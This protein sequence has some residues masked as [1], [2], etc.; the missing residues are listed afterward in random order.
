MTKTQTIVIAIFVRRMSRFAICDSRLAAF[1][2]PPPMVRRRMLPRA[3]LKVFC[4]LFISL[5]CS[6]Q[7]ISQ[8]LI[9]KG[10]LFSKNS[11]FTICT[12]LRFLVFF[13]FSSHFNR[14]LSSTVSLFY[15]NLGTLPIQALMQQDN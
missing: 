1:S 5:L 6:D 13:F 12:F 11:S 8:F 9:P 7:L 3:Y 14:Y 2:T 4:L 10:F 15:V